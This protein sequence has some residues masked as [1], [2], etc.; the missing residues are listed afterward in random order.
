MNFWQG[1]KVRLR[2]IEPSDA[3][4]FAQWNL[5]SER[6]R[7]LDFVWPPTSQATV[8]A[9]VEE[10]SKRKLEND[11]FHWVIE[12][13]EGVPVGSISTHAC[14]SRTGTFSYGVDIAPEH[15]G[16]GYAGEAIFL[17]LK[18]YFD[19]LRYQKVTV[20]VHGDNPASI[21]LHERL[22][23]QKEGTHSRMVFTR[24]QYYDEL[25]YG[26]TVEEFREAYRD[27]LANW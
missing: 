10:Q 23:F 6:A 15:Q 19:E 5:N 26:M 4:V 17:V 18:Y 27:F 3:G 22:G 25:W 1:K 13:V 14:N 11:A 20:P 12:D 8:T 9:W 16:H 24:G 7:N 2:S 21:R